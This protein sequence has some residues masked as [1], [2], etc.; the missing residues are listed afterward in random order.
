MKLL[1]G[2]IGVL[3]FT[4]LPVIADDDLDDDVVTQ[5]VVARKSCAEIKAE[6]DALNAVTEPD[7]DQTAELENLRIMYRRTCML[8]ASGRRTSGRIASMS[9][10][11]RG[12]NKNTPPASGGTPA[13][14]PAA[15]ASDAPAN[16]AS[17]VSAIDEF[18]AKKKANCD[19][20]ESEIAKL[21]AMSDN[22]SVKTVE[23]LRAQFD[24][25]CGAATEMVAEVP[26]QPEQSEEERIAEI[27]ANIEK[28]LCGDGTKPNKFGCC[29]GEK[30]TDMG[31]LVFACCPPEGEC[32]PPINNG[33]GY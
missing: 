20:L 28:G 10:G 26:L 16:A 30:F 22:E 5:T 8:S 7:E 32:F 1:I 23:T 19:A 18:L 31:D 14:A 25:D 4:S 24:A 33:Q 3:L 29:S 6:M 27:A 2:L 11:L 13:N 15:A 12:M 9:V 17:A 21:S